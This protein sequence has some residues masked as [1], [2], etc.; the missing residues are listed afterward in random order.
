MFLGL[1]HEHTFCLI[2]LKANVLLAQS[3]ISWMGD[4]M[5]VS[6]FFVVGFASHG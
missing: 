6:Y 4:V 5:I 1:K 2:F 3:G